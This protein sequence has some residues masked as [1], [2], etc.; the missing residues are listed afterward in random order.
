MLTCKESRNSR[1]SQSYIDIDPEG[2]MIE[3]LSVQYQ[4]P[5]MQLF[6]PLPKDDA[7]LQ[8]GWQS[9]IN[10]DDTTRSVTAP[11][12]G[13]LEVTSNWHFVEKP[14]GALDAIY[15][16]TT[17][18]DY[19]FDASQGLVTKCVATY[20]QGWPERRKGNKTVRTA[21]LVEVRELPAEELAVLAGESDRYF[22]ICQES[23]VLSSRAGREFT[24]TAELLDQAEAKLHELDGKLT[25]EVLKNSLAIKL[26]SLA[27]SR[28]Y[29]IERAEKFGKLLNQP[30]FDWETTDLDG[31]QR[32]L[33]DYRGKVVLL[34][35]WYRGSAG[36]SA[37]C[38]RSSSWPRTSTDSRLPFSA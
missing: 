7:A 35:F 36:A 29:V 3:N 30:S 19:T 17:E 25:V 15:L 4:N 38:R 10:L 2:R 37:P 21:E 34:D 5:A 27:D 18:R 32:K 28:K 22:A 1:E 24:H 13:A 14:Q 31:N 33:A 16:S 11:E 12:K 6:L 8:S 9:H 23:D 20:T 26:K